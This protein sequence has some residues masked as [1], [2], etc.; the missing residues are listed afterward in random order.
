MYWTFVIQLDKICSYLFPAPSDDCR[1]VLT[2]SHT[3]RMVYILIGWAEAGWLQ[4]SKRPALKT[5]SEKCLQWKNEQ[6]EGLQ[7]E[8]MNLAMNKSNILAFV[9]EN[10]MYEGWA[11]WFRVVDSEQSTEEG[12]SNLKLALI[13]IACKHQHVNMHVYTK[14]ADGVLIH[15]SKIH[16]VISLYNE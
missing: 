2:N 15:T 7:E 11:P 1:M 13:T 10:I 14:D 16:P 12:L 4:D 9:T 8:I 3:I 6:P 5:L